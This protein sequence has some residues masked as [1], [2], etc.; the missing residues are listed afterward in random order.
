MG[1]LKTKVNMKYKESIEIENEIENIKSMDEKHI[2]KK[3]ANQVRELEES[4][5]RVFGEVEDIL[6]TP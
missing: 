2:E 3:R 4:L 5:K 1:K 6:N